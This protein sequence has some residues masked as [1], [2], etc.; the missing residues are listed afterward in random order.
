[1]VR[2]VWEGHGTDCM[3]ALLLPHS[4]S[5][6]CRTAKRRDRKELDEVCRSPGRAGWLLVNSFLR[7]EEVIKMRVKEDATEGNRREV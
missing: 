4:H 2:T 7:V 3:R 6:L 5:S 1:M